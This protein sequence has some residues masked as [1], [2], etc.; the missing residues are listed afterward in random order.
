MKFIGD[1][2]PT[3]SRF[4]FE[5]AA[6]LSL[7]LEHFRKDGGI[8]LIVVGQESLVGAL[9]MS[10]CIGPDDCWVSDWTV[11]ELCE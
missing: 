5:K 8:T 9:E 10:L 7:D 4:A 2:S 11:E 3:F 1:L 6:L